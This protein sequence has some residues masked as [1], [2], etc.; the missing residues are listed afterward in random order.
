MDLPGLGSGS[1][2][3]GGE[4]RPR[5]D[6]TEGCFARRGRRQAGAQRQR[7]VGVWGKRRMEG[8]SDNLH[9]DD[10][11]VEARQDLSQ[12]ALG[13]SLSGVEVMECTCPP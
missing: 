10:C 6:L 8:W 9:L 11:G 2:G 13:S 12:L 7:A 3:G 1:P 4:R 5:L